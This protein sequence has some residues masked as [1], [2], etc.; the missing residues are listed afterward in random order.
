MGFGLVIGFIEHLQF[1]TTTNY[2]AIA[3]SHIHQSTTA[4]TKSSQ[5]FTSRFLVTDSDNVLCLRPY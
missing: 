2:S 5:K 3:N 4:H 1:V